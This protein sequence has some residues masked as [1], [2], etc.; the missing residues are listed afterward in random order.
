M[1]PSFQAARLEEILREELPLAHFMDVRVAA[2]DESGLTITAPMG[3][4]ANPHGT[5]FG[6]SIAALGL[7][8][9]W[10]LLRLSLRGEGFEPDIVVQ[11]LLTEYVTPVVT[12]AEVTAVFP[13]PGDWDRFVR[14]LRRRRRGRIL[15]EIQ[16]RS[17]GA[18]ELAA[19]MDAWFVAVAGS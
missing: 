17:A 6:G 12:G 13:E 19:V 14:T 3:P 11:R 4:N 16:V 2:W 15:M 8:A 1:S 7:L 10:G 9:G 18:D 5:M